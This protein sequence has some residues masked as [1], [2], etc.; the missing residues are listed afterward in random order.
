ML[1][2]VKSWGRGWSKHSDLAVPALVLGCIVATMVRFPLAINGDDA[3]IMSYAQRILDGQTPY[4]DFYEINPP[5]IMYL[6]IVPVWIAGQVGQHP[7]VVFNVLVLGVCVWSTLSIRRSMIDLEL[8]GRGIVLTAWVWLA[9]S[10]QYSLTLGQREH[11]FVL[12]YIPFLF[13]RAARWSERPVGMRRAIALGLVAGLVTAIK[14]Q[15]LLVAMVPEAFWLLRHRRP[16]ALVAPEIIAGVCVGCAYLLHF[17]LVPAI[18]RAYLL[19]LLPELW[20]AYASFNDPWSLVLLPVRVILP[21]A[22][23]GLAAAGAGGVSNKVQG[24]LLGG[25][26]SFTVAAF[27][28]I[29]L[30]ARKVWVYHFDP[31]LY[32]SVLLVGIAVVRDTDWRPG[33][34]AVIAVACSALVFAAS[35]Q[36]SPGEAA[37]ESLPS[38]R[39]LIE[40][41]TRPGETV[42]L[43]ACAGLAWPLLLQLGRRNASRYSALVNMLPQFY[44]RDKPF[45]GY[46]SPSELGQSERQFLSN[47]RDDA[48]RYRP[49]VVLINRACW[50]APP[51]FDLWTYLERVGFIDEVFGDFEKLEEL[52]EPPSAWGRPRI[53]VPLIRTRPAGAHDR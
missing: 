26:A 41:R 2:T 6:S 11:L 20:S 8:P 19:E 47:L 37:I 42:M 1:D 44:P 27:A 21:A 50:G 33:R 22:A 52:K 10:T 39:R 29:Y 15:F 24:V 36:I 45:A 34:R 9:W 51:E 31:V 7:I 25:V 12:G 13:L 48:N 28:I 17:A 35:T 53:V 18:G 49:N 30:L 46:R 43:L 5:L 32:G 40:E 4:V 38:T 23:I 16:R 3:L 14:P